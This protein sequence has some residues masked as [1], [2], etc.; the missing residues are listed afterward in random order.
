[1]HILTAHVWLQNKANDK[2]HIQCFEEFLTPHNNGVCDS[3]LNEKL[4]IYTKYHQCYEILQ[5]TV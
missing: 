5:M 1:M 3:E 2:I 4:M